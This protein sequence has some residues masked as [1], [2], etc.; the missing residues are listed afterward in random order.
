MIKKWFLTLSIAE[1]ATLL[2][3]LAIVI[4]GIIKSGYY[5]IHY[6]GTDLRVRVV[7]ARLLN[8]NHSPYFYKW[9]QGDPDK[10]ANPNDGNGFTNGVSVAPGIL[11]LQ[12]VFT[13][14][15]YPLLRIVWTIFQYFLI[16]YIFLF[17][18]SWTTG[19][20]KNKFY[21][22]LIGSVFFL[23]SC[24]WFINIERGQIY[25]FYAFLFCVLYQ[26]YTHK[27]NWSQFAAGIILGLAIYCRPTFVV[28]LIPFIW[29]F[30]RSF[31]AG[32]IASL[33][34]LSIHAYIHSQLWK[35]YFSAMAIYTGLNKPP[36][37]FHNHSYNY[38][39][40]IE[41]AKNLTLYNAMYSCGGIQPI[42]LYFKSFNASYN[43]IYILIYGL[44]AFFL[45]LRFR[46]NLSNSNPENAI[47][48]GFLL[49]I[50]TEYI[51]PF[52]RAGYNMMQWVF[53]VLIILR[54]INIRKIEFVLLVSGLCLIIS[55]PY[56]LPYLHDI[57]ELI[58]L[59]CLVNHIKTDHSPGYDINNK[60]LR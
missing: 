50:I 16:G 12:S 35:D 55:F 13:F 44:I 49:Y 43:S 58:L 40:V 2:I 52:N 30:N 47:L 38:P 32:F 10:F 53:P 18:L 33:I 57:G 34:P 48:F 15:D 54:K 8:T 5:T 59:Y 25:I 17:V 36:A 1:R 9:S 41:G 56:Y 24:L 20:I 29:Q 60:I 23:C 27:N 51:I 14:L 42:Y 7:G 21:I 11:Y 31:V 46:K 39:S 45:T 37:Y 4:G 28:L 6:G 19:P 26:L 22:V 3:I